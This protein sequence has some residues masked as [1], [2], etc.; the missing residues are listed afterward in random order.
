MGQ[1]MFGNPSCVHCGGGTISNGLRG[2]NRNTRRWKCVE[3]GKYF[4]TREYDED[5]VEVERYDVDVVSNDERS[6]F[7]VADMYNEIVIKNA[8]NILVF[9]CVHLPFERP[10]YLEFLLETKKRF[11][12][13]TVVCAGDLLDGHSLSYH[14]HSPDGL[15]PGDELI[16]VKEKLQAWYKA[17]PELYLTYGNHDKIP[18]RKAFTNGLPKTLIRDL[19][20][21]YD[22]PR[23]WKWADRVRVDDIVIMHGTGMS[24]DNAAARWMRQ[25]RKSTV[26]GHI[27]TSLA[28]GYEASEYDR[29]FYM[30]VGCALDQHSYA[31]EY[32]RDFSKRQLIGC[33]VILQEK[34]CATTPI[35]VPMNL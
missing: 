5:E 17:F 10:G 15:S 26:C 22:M 33:G 32:A 25:N 2:Y 3:C 6:T 20:S 8:G 7:A 14:D 28:C 31:A 12:C 13:E 9:A 4:S 24:G 23:T 30:N 16:Q 18:F 27:H 19:N 34:G 21:V 35:P 11:G 29:L 1:R